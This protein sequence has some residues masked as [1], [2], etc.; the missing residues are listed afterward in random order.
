VTDE[1]LAAQP[2]AVATRTG[3]EPEAA[4]PEHVF[5]PKDFRLDL[6]AKLA[7][8]EDEPLPN[9]DSPAIRKLTWE[10]VVPDRP[11]SS[12]PSA[13][14]LVPLPPP[15]RVPPPPPP[16][17]SVT[18]EPPAPAVVAPEPVVAEVVAEAAVIVEEEAFIEAE[19]FDDL[20]EVDEFDDEELDEDPE[21]V[22]EAEPVVAARPVVEPEVNRLAFVPDLIDD[23][24]PIELPAITPSGPIVAHAPS[25]YTP[26]LAET[27]YVVPPRPATT[28]VAA[29]PAPG[30]AKR[31]KKKPKRHLFRSFVTLVFLFGLLAG[32]AFAAKKYL[33][34]AATWTADMKP[35][36]DEVAT[37]RGLQ[38]KEAVDVTPL[39]VADYAKR[40]AESAI[41]TGTGRAATWRALGL[42]NGDLDFEA[43][44]RQALNDNPAFY[45]PSTQ[46]I[47]VSAD[48]QP[49]P[50]LYRFAMHRAMT[51]AL[52]D[53]QFDWSTRLVT[54]T[55]AAALAIRAT[56]DADALAVANSLAAKDS[57]EL[58]APELLAFVQGHGNTIAPSQ[59]AATVAGRAG[60]A[61]RPTIA[62]M[63]SDPTALATFEQATPSDDLL[64][65]FGR[66]AAAVA[67]PAGT[68][69]MMFWYY[70]LASRIDDSQAWSAVTHWTGDSMVTPTASASQCVDA[71]IAANDAAGAAVLLTAF[72]TW[73]AGATPE[74]TTTVVA[75][76]GNQVAVR[77][78]DPTVAISAQVASKVPVVFG[79]AGVERALVQAA[80]SAAGGGKVDAACLVRAARQRGIVLTSPADDAPVLAV[81]WQAAFVAANLDL[82][83]ECVAA[84]ADPAAAPAAVPTP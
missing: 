44:G 84:A 43:I 46:T 27:F 42:L 9:L 77:A 55:P 25:I 67:S 39:P 72:E 3:D 83:T 5:S 69:G 6:R 41:G 40:L 70:V 49:Q 59:F 19:E 37:T 52:L 47:L 57:P 33:L 80:D 45:D 35:L 15:R 64:F 17:A 71:K 50:H 23:D 13:A 38:F 12:A 62:S 20:E 60:V 28:T 1:E 76:D 36:A 75:I 26:V 34:H 10:H 61:L 11:A 8:A 58:L 21:P 74:S 14:A 56:F 68:Q 4:A 31:K 7:V 16:K 2:G 51:M 82:A 53:Q 18:L 32:G 79:G 24:S 63:A 22:V 78:C 73:A 81:D 65:D 29:V 30:K 66:P 48:L 54:A